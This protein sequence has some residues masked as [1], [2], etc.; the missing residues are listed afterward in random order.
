MRRRFSFDHRD[1]TF[2]RILSIQTNN[3]YMIIIS[4]VTIFAIKEKNKKIKNHF[5]CFMFL[6]IENNKDCYI[7]YSNLYLKKKIIVLHFLKYF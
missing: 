5:G 6:K 1:A 2:I 3:V 7:K 4:L